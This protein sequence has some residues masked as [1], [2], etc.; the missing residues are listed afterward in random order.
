M[1]LVIVRSLLLL[2]CFGVAQTFGVEQLFLGTAL[3]CSL[4]AMFSIFCSATHIILISHVFG[5]LHFSHPFCFKSLLFCSKLV[6][7]NHRE[8]LWPKY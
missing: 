1:K 3:A 4:Q 8:V 5:L 2:A 6:K 7:Y